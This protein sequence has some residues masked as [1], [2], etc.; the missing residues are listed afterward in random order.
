[1][2]GRSGR[3][4]VWSVPFPL[5]NLITIEKL[6]LTGSPSSFFR[7]DKTEIPRGQMT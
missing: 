2:K 7:N 6:C 3:G 1:M 4:I 5:E